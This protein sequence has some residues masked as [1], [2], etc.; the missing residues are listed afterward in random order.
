MVLTSMEPGSAGVSGPGNG[1]PHLRAVLTSHPNADP[2]MAAGFLVY[3]GGAA[4]R[5]EEVVNA[6]AVRCASGAMDPITGVAESPARSSRR[7]DI[8]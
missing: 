7:G 3:P 6:G 1:R 5:M 2:A 8:P 4:P